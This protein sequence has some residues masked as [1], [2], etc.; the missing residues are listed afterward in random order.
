MAVVK[1]NALD[2][3]LGS[4]E[5]CPGFFLICGESLLVRQAFNTLVAFLL[6]GHNRDF[7][8]EIQDG[9]TISMGDIVEQ[10]TT[11]SFMSPRKVIAVKNAPL[12]SPGS[13]ASEISYAPTDME[14]LTG[15]I[16]KGIPDTHTLVMTSSSLDKRKKI[17]K[18]IQS[19]G[20]IIDC[21]V[22]TGVRK[23]DL[24]EQR[25]VLQEISRKMLAA[26][27]KTMD[28]NA[29]HALVEQ[30][31][32]A[33]ETFAR[34]IE[35]LVT[36]SG[37]HPVIRLTDIQAVVIRD[38]KDPVFNLTN[39]VQERDAARA[40]TV[41][42]SLFQEGFHPLQILRSLENQVR[43]L[44]LVK[45]FILSLS[46]TQGPSYH[47]AMTFNVFKQEMMPVILSHDETEKSRAAGLD[48]G[49]P[50]EKPSGK[51]KTMTTDLIM[52]P[53]PNSPYPLFQVFKNSE[54]F[55]L[56]ELRQAMIAL[57]DMDYRLK[58]ASSE[59]PISLENFILNLCQ[60]GGSSHGEKDQDHRH[61][62]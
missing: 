7:C 23:E 45:S 6:K 48:F 34:N 24:D 40:M 62:L 29:F 33:P 30:T 60:K 3:Y 52:A 42:C 54:N 56:N 37:A 12:F 35:K 10:V 27:Q 25:A 17:F 18:T 20:S 55:S 2:S 49:F 22:S 61:H 14:L 8:L 21:M 16:E 4:G 26:A 9:K 11:F 36:Y 50:S 19:H 57:A 13:T 39:A 28:A 38:K 32:F 41:L 43:K 59:A 15:L 1:Y 47:K 58:S 31:G 5:P 53:N 51:A 46:N 44:L